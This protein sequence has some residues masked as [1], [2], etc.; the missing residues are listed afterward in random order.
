MGK[1]ALWRAVPTWKR[2]WWARFALLCPPYK[3]IWRDTLRPA[4]SSDIVQNHFATV[5]PCAVFGEVNALP[6]PKL[7]RTISNRN[8]KRNAGHHGLHVSRHVVGSFS[9]VNPAG[10]GWRKAVKRR[11]EI[12]A[13]VRIGI[14]LYQERRRGVADEHKHDTVACSATG[15]EIRN[16]LLVISKNPWPRVSMTSVAAI[17]NSGA[18]AAIA[19]S[20][21]MALFLWRRLFQ[22]SVVSNQ[23]SGM[24]AACWLPGPGNVNAYQGRK[25]GDR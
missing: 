18:M 6:T 15:D 12:G 10:V 22:G 3:S 14:L 5:R 2:P 16:V 8:V 7:K 11:A 25:F 24:I 1:G 13:N 21:L 4:L 20:L 17:I 23:G 9:V 19:E